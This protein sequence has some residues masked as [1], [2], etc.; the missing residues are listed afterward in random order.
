MWGGGGCGGEK[1]DCRHVPG[2]RVEFA[3]AGYLSPNQYVTLAGEWSNRSPIK[4]F[5]SVSIHACLW[6]ICLSASG[7]P[8]SVA[9]SV[10]RPSNRSN[11]PAMFITDYTKKW[12]P[13][14][15][16]PNPTNPSSRFICPLRHATISA[17]FTTTNRL[18]G[19]WAKTTVSAPGRLK[20]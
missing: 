17:I 7:S 19:D 13:P 11:R 2:R 10:A 16:P 9:P 12:Y 8:L 4:V 18:I 1:R 5:T 3:A 14:F 20:I 6:P 15:C